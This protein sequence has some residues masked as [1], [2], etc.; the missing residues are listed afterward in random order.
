MTWPQRPN[1]PSLDLISNPQKES[2]YHTHT[3][4]EKGL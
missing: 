1:Y 2:A 3:N 4:G